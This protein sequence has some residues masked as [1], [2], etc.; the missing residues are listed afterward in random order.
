MFVSFDEIRRD[1]LRIKTS[2]FNSQIMFLLFDEKTGAFAL[3]MF[4]SK[5][6]ADE[7]MSKLDDLH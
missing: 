5:N 1:N 7:Y 6:A 4:M 3:K 2:V